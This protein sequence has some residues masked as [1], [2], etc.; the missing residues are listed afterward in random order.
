VVPVDFLADTCLLYLCPI[1]TGCRDLGGRIRQRSG[2]S[3]LSRPV[4][5]FLYIN[6]P[7]QLS[8]FRQKLSR[9]PWPRLRKQLSKLVY[10]LSS[11]FFLVTLVRGTYVGSS[12]SPLMKLSE[13]LS[14]H[15]FCRRGFLTC[16][17][18]KRLSSTPVYRQIPCPSG[19]RIDF[20]THPNVGSFLKVTETLQ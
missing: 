7:K 1:R 5:R 9:K 10:D 4:A 6:A 3:A 17:G 11:P 8:R 2:R 13:P 15:S 19:A 12:P 16:C 20:S 14:C 18:E